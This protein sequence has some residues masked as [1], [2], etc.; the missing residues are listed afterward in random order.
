VVRTTNNPQ[1]PRATSLPATPESGITSLECGVTLNAGRPQWVP[2]RARKP[3]PTRHRMSL[4][5]RV[6]ATR[7]RRW[8]FFMA[9]ILIFDAHRAH[10]LFRARN[11]GLPTFSSNRNC[12]GDQTKF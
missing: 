11:S 12:G 6:C 7:V 3:A 10:R 1:S 5:Q 2:H 8:H 4:L 9:A